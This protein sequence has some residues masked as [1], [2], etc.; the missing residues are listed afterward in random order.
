[1]RYWLGSS[2]NYT[3]GIVQ[4][5]V[6]RLRRTE[7]GGHCPEREDIL[8]KAFSTAIGENSFAWSVGDGCIV[9]DKWELDKNT[10]GAGEQEIMVIWILGSSQ[11]IAR[12]VCL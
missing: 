1:M 5:E 11:L 8:G 3:K 10:T 7:V 2:W 12:S 6:S 4:N 9:V